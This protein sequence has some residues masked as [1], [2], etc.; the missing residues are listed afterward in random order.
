MATIVL[1]SF[2]SKKLSYR[3]PARDLCVSALFRAA[4]Q[5]AQMVSPN[6]ILIRSAECGLVRPADEIEPHNITVQDL[7]VRP[8]KE[9]ARKVLRALRR[10]CDLDS[11][12]F[13]IL[14]GRIYREHLLPR[15]KSYDIPLNRLSI[16]RQLQYL[17][18]IVRKRDICDEPHQL[19][20]SL[21]RPCFPFTTDHIRRNGIYILFDDR[22]HAH[23]VDKTVRCCAHRT[24]SIIFSLKAAFR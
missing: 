2:A 23:G 10:Y 3:A 12:D 6:R 1:I 13:V 5:Y 8:R 19:F 22:E 4:L 24:K 14:A 9:W 17:A 16:G 7:P 20:P 21:F 15:L 11:D 18:Q